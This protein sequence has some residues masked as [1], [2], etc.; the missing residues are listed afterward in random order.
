[1]GKR[2]LFHELSN[3]I[4]S[5]A[6]TEVYKFAGLEDYQFE[7]ILAYIVPILEGECM[8][9]QIQSGDIIRLT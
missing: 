3:A 4:R 8:A 9:F 7:D 2:I 5:L 1:M 6:E